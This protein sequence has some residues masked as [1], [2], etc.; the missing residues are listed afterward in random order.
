[1]ASLPVFRAAVPGTSIALRHRPPA[2][3]TT[4]ACEWPAP[5]S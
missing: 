1:M 5:P 4:N 3:V 2:S